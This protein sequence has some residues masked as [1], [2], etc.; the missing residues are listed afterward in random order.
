VLPAEI[1][2]HIAVEQGSARGLERYIGA[3]GRVIGME[4]F[5]AWRRSRSCSAN[6]GSNPGGSS[7]LAREM[8]GGKQSRERTTRLRSRQAARWWRR[9]APW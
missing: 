6:L 5:G 8:L 7:D 9:P 3:T 4:T 1:K 2:A